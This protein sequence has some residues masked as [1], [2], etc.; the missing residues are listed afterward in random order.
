MYGMIGYSLPEAKETCPVFKGA[1]FSY[2]GLL[3]QN[4]L[5][6]K[7]ATLLQVSVLIE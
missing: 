6:T 5:D 1:G 7:S 3:W 4:N 2:S